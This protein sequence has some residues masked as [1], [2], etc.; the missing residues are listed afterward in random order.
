M[1]KLFLITALVSLS[2]TG[3]NQTSERVKIAKGVLLDYTIEKN[4]SNGVVTNTYFYWGFQNQ[5]YSSIV[6]IG[7][8]FFTQKKDLQ[9]FT[10][11]LKVIAKK[12]NGSNIDITI[13][14]GKL[15]LYDFD[16]D[17]VYITDRNGKYTTIEKKKLLDIT[18]EIEQYINYLK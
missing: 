12:E 2:F 14:G 4:I 6:D 9:L 3:L 18:N 13:K 8:L 1:K 16:D 11:M 15:N 7:S 5:E 10:D 17:F